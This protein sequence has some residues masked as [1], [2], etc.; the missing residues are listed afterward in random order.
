MHAFISSTAQLSSAMNNYRGK[1]AT[2]LGTGINCDVSE[3]LSSPGFSV[4]HI[5]TQRSI[6]E[7]V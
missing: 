3:C 5:D 4:P 2:D 6:L 7:V 1:A